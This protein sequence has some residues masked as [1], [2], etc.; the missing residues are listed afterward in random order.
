MTAYSLTVDGFDAATIAPYSPPVYETLADGGCGE[1]TT[2]LGLPR[3]AEHAALRKNATVILRL[4][5]LGVWHGYLTDYD[6]ETGELV[7][8]G[9]A[10]RSKLALNGSGQATLSVGTAITQAIARGWDVTNPAAVSGTVNGTV[11]GVQTMAELLAAY[12]TQTTQRWGVNGRGQVY[13]RADPTEPQWYLTP[14]AAV[15]SPTT[16]G[17]ATSLAGRYLES[18]RS[19]ATAYV[20]DPSGDEEP[21]DLTGRGILTLGQAQALLTSMLALTRTA[22]AWTAGIEVS[23]ELVRTEGGTPAALAAITAGSVMRLTGLPVLAAGGLWVDALIGRTRYQ[24]GAPTIYLEPI[25]TAPRT[26]AD[27]IAAT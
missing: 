25:S 22:P 26:L 15:L 24:A 20:G 11:E 10:Y 19:I 14:G 3:W 21:V 2:T 7:A 4:G 27:V 23:A 12:A 17:Q 18:D 6:R 1:L 16:E 8:T 13:L 5:S 9:Q